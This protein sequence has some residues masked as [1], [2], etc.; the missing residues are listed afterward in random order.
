M[1]PSRYEHYLDIAGRVAETTKG[2]E[3]VTAG[4]VCILPDLAPDI[5]GSAQGLPK[6][7]DCDLSA[8]LQAVEIINGGALAALALRVYKM[9]APWAE[10][11]NDAKDYHSKMASKTRSRAGFV[12]AANIIRYTLFGECS[13]LLMAE[14]VRRVGPPTVRDADDL[15]RIELRVVCDSDIQGADNIETF[16]Y[17]W[18]HLEESQPLM[19]ELGLSEHARDVA[20][21][22]E[23]TEPMLLLADHLAGAIHASKGLGSVPPPRYCSEAD[24][25]EI[26]SAYL[27]LPH[28][29][30]VE[31]VFDI[32]YKEI[33]LDTRIGQLLWPSR[34]SD[35]QPLPK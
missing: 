23:Q 30:V 12:K 29:E 27:E 35:Q 21:E 15:S 26:G 18:R 11:W 17:L 14:T 34:N 8:A 2:S 6:W 24:L 9:P 5:R 20:L 25:K 1:V 4:A 7:R 33:F 3:F 22:T 28:F 13:A 31:Q 19:R 32:P 10:F 16:R